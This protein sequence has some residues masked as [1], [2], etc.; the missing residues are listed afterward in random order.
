MT[1]DYD[2]AL[3][4]LSSGLVVGVK[5]H[6]LGA[7]ITRAAQTIGGFGELS[8]ITHVGIL[9]QIGNTMYIYEMD[10][11]HNV[12]RPFSQYRSAEMWVYDC[13]VNPHTVV[14]HLIDAM[15]TPITYSTTDLIR[16]GAS[17]L[18]HGTIKTGGDAPDN[19]VCSTFNA[20]VLQQAGWVPPAGFP[21]MPAPAQ[22]CQALT[23][24][25][26]IQ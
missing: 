24:K 20:W 5:G 7:S 26:K 12:I 14:A 2:T 9:R 23:L 15:A 1:H 6:T 8:D 19:L 3:P 4:L 17:I 11:R 22:L 13:P 21:T 18:T 10:G 25:F 16:I